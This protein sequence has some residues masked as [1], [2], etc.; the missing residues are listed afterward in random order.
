MQVFD[1]VPLTTYNPQHTNIQQ[2]ESWLIKSD[3]QEQTAERFW[4][5]G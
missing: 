4:V 2:R 5:R 1:K 3:L